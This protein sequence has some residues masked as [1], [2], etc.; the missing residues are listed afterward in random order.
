[1]IYY[2]EIVEH[3]GR[4]EVE[5][6]LEYDNPIG[7]SLDLSVDECNYN[8]SDKT[9]GQS[10]YSY[11]DIYNSIMRYYIENFKHM[12]SEVQEEFLMV[13]SKEDLENWYS[14][15]IGYENLVDKYNYQYNEILKKKY[16]ELINNEE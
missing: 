13:V 12:S 5:L 11:T 16:M 8:N 4:E 14:E 6:M 1:M 15:D 3:F 9:S 10:L 2:K 7:V